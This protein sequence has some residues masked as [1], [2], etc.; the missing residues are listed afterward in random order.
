MELEKKYNIQDN[1]IGVF[2]NFFTNELIQKYIEY[3]N[4]GEKNNLVFFR[5]EQNL[6]KDTTITTMG[7]E[8]AVKYDNQELIHNI[9]SQIYP[10]YV[11]KFPLLNTTDK[12]TVYEVKIQKTKPS[13]GY[14]VWHTELMG[15]KDQSRLFAFMLYLNDVTEGGETEFLYQ[16]CRVTPVKNRFVLWPAGITHMHRGNPPLSNDKF[17]LTGW[18]EYL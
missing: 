5:K 16:K 6:R 2:D 11:E 12:H 17:V 1:F 9:Y 3:Y 4:Y 7:L 8:R 15:K 14:H 13:E 10:L 18:L